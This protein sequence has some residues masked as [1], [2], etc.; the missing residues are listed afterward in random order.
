MNLIAD[1]GN[2]STKLAV[3]DNSKLITL[4]RQ[5]SPGIDFLENLI[6]KWQIKK[7]TVLP[8]QA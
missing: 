5:E 4:V 3:F 2:S 1:I 7:Q 8:L 6:G